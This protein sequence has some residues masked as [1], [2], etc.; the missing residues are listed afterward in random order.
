MCA[1]LRKAGVECPEP[2]CGWNLHRYGHTCLQTSSLHLKC[3]CAPWLMKPSVAAS[4]QEQ[5]PARL[6][7]K[8][9]TTPRGIQQQSTASRTHLRGV[10]ANGMCS[11]PLA[12]VHASEHPGIR[13][14]KSLRGE[15]PGVAPSC[16][17]HS[18]WFRPHD[19]AE[20]AIIS[21][22]LVNYSKE[23]LHES[24][25]QDGSVGFFCDVLPVT[26]GRAWCAVSSTNA[27]HPRVAN[28]RRHCQTA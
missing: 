13:P 10:I 8:E 7:H 18:M 19:G 22:G 15:Q 26:F 4:T 20:R 3:T 21:H 14:E 28:G 24:L 5:R 12:Y 6:Q 17:P 9:G 1:T 23:K 16:G 27:H 2:T 25:R 11:T